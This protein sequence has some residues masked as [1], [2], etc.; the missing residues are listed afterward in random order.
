MNQ[1]VTLKPD[2][3]SEPH[4]DSKV[5]DV[6]K[7]ALKIIIHQDFY[8]KILDKIHTLKKEKQQEKGEWTGD[9][10]RREKK[11]QWILTM[12]GHPFQEISICTKQNSIYQYFLLKIGGKGRASEQKYTPGADSPQIF[13]SR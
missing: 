3:G 9:V 10:W 4:R 12:Q 7:S 13:F 6:Q 5:K 1:K 8:G 11:Q 2:A